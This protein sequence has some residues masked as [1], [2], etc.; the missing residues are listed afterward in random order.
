MTEVDRKEILRYLGCRGTADAATLL[1]IEDCV[2][3]LGSA[4]RPRHVARRFPITRRAGISIAGIEIT[5]HSLE[6]ALKG[7]SETYIF[8]ATLGEDVDILLRRYSA[9]SV[10]RATVMQAAAAAYIEAYCDE[11]CRGFA[12]EASAE[13]L[14]LRPRFSPGYGDLPL[15]LQRGILAVLEAQRSLG[16]VLT[17]SLLLLPTKSVTAFI[18]LSDQDAPCA[19]SG[20]A[21]CRKTDCAYKKELSIWIFSTFSENV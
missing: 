2:T 4:A 21:V 6:A 16:I 9:A 13:D 8:A 18:G 5:S 7:C 19:P 10:S 17:D 14:S 1:L 11:V 12:K 15:S 20:C 3:E